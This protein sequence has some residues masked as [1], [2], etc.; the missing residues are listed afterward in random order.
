MVNG[1]EYQNQTGL[2]QYRFK[3]SRSTVNAEIINGEVYITSN[4]F[5]DFMGYSTDDGINLYKKTA[6]VVC[7]R[8]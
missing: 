3:A 1:K 7:R 8:A 5:A 4:T 6:G 2:H